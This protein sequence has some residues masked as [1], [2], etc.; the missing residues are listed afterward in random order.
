M[1]PEQIQ[2]VKSTVPVLQVH[3]EE[4]TR[5]FYRE[6]LDAHPELNS[7][8]NAENQKDG[9]Q[10]RRLAGAILAYAGHVDR[11]AQLDGAVGKIAHT[12]VGLKVL[13]AQ[14]PIV[15]EHLLGAIKIVLG[16]AATPEIL[17]A[18]AAAY[19]QLAAI[20]I[21]REASLYSAVGSQEN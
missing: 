17:E 1:T 16:E 3:G 12:H 6:L 4:I 14:Y 8:F 18:W 7:M 11:V 19:G 2:I 5:V 10:S 21:D 15:G 20:M 9:S 13:P